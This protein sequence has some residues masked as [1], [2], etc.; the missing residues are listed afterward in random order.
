MVCSLVWLLRLPQHNATVKSN[1][2]EVSSVPASIPEETPS[3]VENGQ[4]SS[5]K[6]AVAQATRRPTAA[7]GDDY[8]SWDEDD[9]DD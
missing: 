6:G 2:G 9:E 5:K 8:D 1:S 7:K 3:S 4:D